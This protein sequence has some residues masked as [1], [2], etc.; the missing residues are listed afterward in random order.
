MQYEVRL[1]GVFS[2]HF[3]IIAGLPSGIF[4]FTSEVLIALL[5]STLATCRYSDILGCDTM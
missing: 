4:L 2:L 1:L 5:P 3:N